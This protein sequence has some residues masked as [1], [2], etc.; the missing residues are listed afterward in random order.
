MKI[1]AKLWRII[2]ETLLVS[3]EKIDTLPPPHS[4]LFTEKTE[5]KKETTHQIKNNIKLS[6]KGFIV[7]IT[8]LTVYKLGKH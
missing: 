2:S 8:R 5:L 1:N 7:H 3:L 4:S 6:H